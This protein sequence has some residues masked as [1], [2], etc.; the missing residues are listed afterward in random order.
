MKKNKK[1]NLVNKLYVGNFNFNE[2]I[3]IKINERKNCFFWLIRYNV[4]LYFFSYFDFYHHHGIIFCANIVSSCVHPNIIIS[5]IKFQLIYLPIKVYWKHMFCTCCCQ[6]R[7]NAKKREAQKWR[8]IHFIIL[9]LPI[10]T[11]A[12]THTHIGRQQVKDKIIKKIAW[13]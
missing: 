8:N 9:L 2:E 11:H 12:H 3:C 13:N 10:L 7:L 6:N 1:L 5:T 4:T